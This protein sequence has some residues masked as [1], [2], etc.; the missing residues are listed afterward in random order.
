MNRALLIALCPAIVC[1]LAQAQVM[2]NS[3]DTRKPELF[4]QLVSGLALNSSGYYNTL[5]EAWSQYTI[6][7]GQCL[8]GISE[9]GRIRVRNAIR[10]QGV[11]GGST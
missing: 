10:P 4:Y 5:D 9:Q 7:D 2:A 6:M 8:R 3:S 11:P 1:P